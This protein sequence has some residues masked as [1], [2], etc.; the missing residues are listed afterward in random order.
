M[1]HSFQNK[2][3]EIKLINYQ[4]YISIVSI[5]VILISLVLLYN[6]QLCL[7]KEKPILSPKSAK[8]VSVF[9]KTLALITIISF[10][11]IN[12][13]LYKI[14]EEEQ[15]NLTPYKLQISASI[16]TL[17][18]GIIV[19]YVVATAKVENVSDVENPII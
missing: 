10:L 6:E 11:Y 17:V 4:T 7:K 2:K 15:E 13:L 8:T 9:N 18:A 1:A 14:S 16:F 12:Y 19:L 5:I 3:K